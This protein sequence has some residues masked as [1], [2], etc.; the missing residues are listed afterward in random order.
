MKIGLKYSFNLCIHVFEWFGCSD[1]YAQGGVKFFVLF[2]I[3][4]FW[5][6]SATRSSRRSL[7]L[8]LSNSLPK[9]H[10]LPKR[11]SLKLK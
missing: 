2:L 1:H 6:R 3:K 8:N 4:M 9:H 5:M 11:H 10:F 7:S